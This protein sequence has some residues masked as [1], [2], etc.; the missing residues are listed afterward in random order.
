MCAYGWASDEPSNCPSGREVKD[1]ES[2]SVRRTIRDEG[3]A[4][5]AAIKIKPE[6]LKR[7]VGNQRLDW[8]FNR[9]D[10]SIGR[11]IYVEELRRSWNQ[12]FSKLK[13][14]CVEHPKVVGLVH[15]KCLNR[16]QSIGWTPH[17]CPIQLSCWVGNRAVVS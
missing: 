4:V 3:D 12:W 1:N 15:L 17:I 13:R 8:Q 11:E 6:V 16:K 2:L 9:T 7:T 14:P 5:S 10:D